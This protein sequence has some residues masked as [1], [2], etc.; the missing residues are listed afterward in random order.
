M[1]TQIQ[2]KNNIDDIKKKDN[3]G[4]KKEKKKDN[5]IIVV[6]SSKLY[7]VLLTNN[8]VITTTNTYKN[9]CSKY[10]Y[11]RLIIFLPHIF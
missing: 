6:D 5:V 4:L 9:E 2:M 7:I 10:R 1:T 11:L 8:N 3:V